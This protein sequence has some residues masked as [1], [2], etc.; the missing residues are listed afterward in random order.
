M[1]HVVSESERKVMM[2]PREE[3]KRQGGCHCVSIVLLLLIVQ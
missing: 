2:T 3:L 1:R